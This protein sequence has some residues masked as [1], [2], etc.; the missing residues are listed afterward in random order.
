MEQTTATLLRRLVRPSPAPAPLT[1][2]RALRIAMTRAAERS[3]SLPLAVLGVSEDE[4]PLDDLLSR[5]EEGL[6]IVA[7][8]QGEEPVGLIALDAEAR[9]AAIE[10]QALGR[11]S[12]LP[13][14]PREIT[15]ADVT[16]ARPLLSAFLEEAE[17]AIAGTSLAGWLHGPALAARL[18]GPREATMLLGDGLYRV[19]RLSLDLDAGG[20]QGLILLMVRLPGQ[21]RP[22]PAE[23][24]P[25]PTVAPQVLAAQVALDAVLHRLSLPL[26]EAEALHVGQLLPLPGVTVASVRLEGSGGVDLGSAR[27]GQ[28]AG[29]RAIRIEQPPPPALDQLPIPAES[30]P[31]MLESALGPV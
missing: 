16:L 7:L 4:G 27:L 17:A 2:A 20:R 25:A 21:A 12:P 1:P 30:L 15:V 19:V 11:V 22:T 14:E 23:A 29:M 26:A 9:A 31:P 3:I 8:T 10:V 24:V 28:V 13:P 5:L 6:M 18:P